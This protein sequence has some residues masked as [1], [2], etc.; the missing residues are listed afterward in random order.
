[1][2]PENPHATQEPKE[3]VILGKQV[4]PVPAV[5]ERAKSD[6]KDVIQDN[7][8]N[9]LISIKGTNTISQC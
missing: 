7:K 9:I 5:E 6:L 1:M 4:S 2:I 3:N 8:P